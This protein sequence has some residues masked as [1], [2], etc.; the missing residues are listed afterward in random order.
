MPDDEYDELLRQSGTDP[1]QARMNI[2]AP[3]APPEKSWMENFGGLFMRAAEG[4]SS[5]TLDEA[6]ALGALVH[7]QPFEENR[8]RFEQEQKEIGDVPGG[9]VAE[10]VGAVAPWVA[11]P[12]VAGAKGAALGLGQLGASVMG[13]SKGG[14]GERA[15]QTAEYLKDNPVETALSM[16]GPA[17]GQALGKASKGLQKLR[18]QF[19]VSALMNDAERSRLVKK[20]GPEAIEE[21]GGRMIDQGLNKARGWTKFLRPASASDMGENIVDLLDRAGTQLGTA[22]DALRKGGHMVDVNNTADELLWKAAEAADEWAVGPA[23]ELEKKAIDIFKQIEAKTTGKFETPLGNA[24]DRRRFFDKEV[25]WGKK[26]GDTTRAEDLVNRMTAVNLREDIGAALANIANR[27]GKAAEDVSK[28]VEGN[29]LYNLGSTLADAA[30]KG[31]QKELGN[32]VNPVRRSMDV[33]AAKALGLPTEIAAAL[34]VGGKASKF[35]AAA[36]TM[37]N[38]SRLAEGA[39]EGLKRLLPGSLAANTE[40][41]PPDKAET[42]NKEIKQEINQAQNEGGWNWMKKLVG[43]E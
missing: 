26:K 40:D 14:L 13:K 22:E 29:E 20:Y 1:N 4:A 37:N 24:I 16:A 9:G 38:L 33:V 23:K 8:Q 41:V 15:E 17:A 5:N 28:W 19:T 34:G 10:T 18:K 35:N 11:A 3:A 2:E 32:V 31:T 43:M 30:I 27:G 36:G 39:G 7:G 25:D 42:A 21:L 12:A 6:R